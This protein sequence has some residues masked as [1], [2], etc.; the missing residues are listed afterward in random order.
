MYYI[1]LFQKYVNSLAYCLNSYLINT[2][3]YQS[4]PEYGKKSCHIL[5]IDAK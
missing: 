1:T 2:I 4:I 5:E 3:T